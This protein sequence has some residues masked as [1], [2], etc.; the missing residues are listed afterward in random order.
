MRKEQSCKGVE[1]RQHKIAIL[2]LSTKYL[3]LLLIP[4]VIAFIKSQFDVFSFIREFWSSIIIV[5]FSLFVGI[6]RWRNIKFCVKDKYFTYKAG[7][8]CRQKLNIPFSAVTAITTERPFYLRPFGVVK[9]YIE[10]DAIAFARSKK[11]PDISI[12]SNDR[13]CRALF[14]SLYVETQKTRNTHHFGK[15]QVM[16]FS[17]VFSSALSGVI[18]LVTLVSQGTRL[19]GQNLEAMVITTVEDAVTVAE[20]VL[21]FVPKTG[22]AI[23][24]IIGA[25][26]LVSVIRNFFRH[27]NFSVSKK[28]DNIYIYKGILT[29]RRFLINSKK[30]NYADIRQSLFMKMC[31]VMSVHINCSGYGK[32]KDEIP[33]FLPVLRQER[34]N[35]ILSEMLPDFKVFKNDIYV[36]KKVVGR[37]LFLPSLAI[38]GLFAGGLVVANFFPL[39]QDMTKFV[40]VMA[41]IPCIFILFV[42]IYCYCTNGMAY[43]DDE[44]VIRYDKWFK[45]HTAIIPKARVAKVTVTQTIFQRFSGSCNVV[46]NSYSEHTGSHK[47]IGLNL[48]EAARLIKSAGIGK[49]IE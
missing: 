36:V 4:L 41:E 42:K 44:I 45:I 18:F 26:W 43:H 14:D 8:I 9:I 20:R 37:Y 23:T 17:L 40:V 1:L 10:T 7:V 25:G 19:L 24:I 3:W 12:T 34:V 30:I 11:S 29:K 2:S 31:A 28:G 48:I 49:S 21:K 22:L 39:W 32:D 38:I 47:V 15:L 35:K 6:I 46:V 33:V 13:V 5:I 16:F 27:G